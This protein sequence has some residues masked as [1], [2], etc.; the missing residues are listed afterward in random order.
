[1]RG[2]GFFGRTRRE[3]RAYPEVDLYEDRFFGRCHVRVQSRYPFT[4]D[5]CLNGRAMLT[6]PMD[7]LAY[8]KAGRF[9]GPA[10]RDR[11]ER[12]EGCA[13]APK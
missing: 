2:K 7:E 6:R 11:I 9:N 12:H 5:I 4:V 1:M 3:R 8:R 13:V 10:S